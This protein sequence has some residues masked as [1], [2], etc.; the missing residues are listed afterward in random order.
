MTEDRIGDLLAIENEQLQKLRTIVLNAIEEEKLLSDK[1][2]DFE[3]KNLSL[4]SR[5]ADRVARFGGSWLFIIS[6]LA[7]MG[8]WIGANAFLLARPF[9]RYPFILLNLIL[10][11]IAAIQA[12]IILMSQNRTEQKDRQR[13]VNDYLVNLKAEIEIRN[14]HQ[15]LDLL[16]SEQ[17]KTLFEIQREQV[18]MINELKLVINSHM[19]KEA[20]Q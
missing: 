15:K 2:Y 18:E 9:D 3:E 16:I 8:L 6:F 11:T 7:L 12:P 1:L 20:G 17:M 4:G 5:V 10:S 19:T 14:M 13:S